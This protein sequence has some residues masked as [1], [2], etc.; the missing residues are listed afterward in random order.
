MTAIQFVPHYEVRPDLGR[1]V[2]ERL[3]VP[4]AMRAFILKPYR[5]FIL[6]YMKKAEK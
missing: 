4:P 3:A 2:R 6:S 5:A 1:D